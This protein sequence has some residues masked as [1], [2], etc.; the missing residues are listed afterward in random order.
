MCLYD[1]IKGDRLLILHEITN[2]QSHIDLIR[3]PIREQLYDFDVNCFK[4]NKKQGLFFRT[5][6]SISR[7]IDDFSYM[8]SLFDKIKQRTCRMLCSTIVVNEEREKSIL[9]LRVKRLIKMIKKG[10]QIENMSSKFSVR[11][12]VPDDICMICHEKSTGKWIYFNQSR[13]CMCLECFSV[14]LETELSK[15]DGRVTCPL[16]REK[17]LP[18]SMM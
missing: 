11:M 3:S 9:G 13:G 17:I 16:T 12:D 15:G 6:H 7:Q 14:F 4:F 18:W 2:E 1:D 5:G 8:L 10:W